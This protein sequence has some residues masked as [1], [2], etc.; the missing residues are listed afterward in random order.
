M[1]TTP[2][3]VIGPVLLITSRRWRTCGQSSNAWLRSVQVFGITWRWNGSSARPS[4]STTSSSITIWMACR[5]SWTRRRRG[6]RHGSPGSDVA[7]GS[8]SQAPPPMRLRIPRSGIPGRGSSRKTKFYAHNSSRGRLRRR[9]I[10]RLLSPAVPTGTAVPLV[11][12]PVLSGAMLLGRREAEGR[13]EE[14]KRRGS[15]GTLEVPTSPR[16]AS[17]PLPRR[18]PCLA[19]DLPELRSFPVLS[20]PAVTWPVARCPAR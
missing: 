11:L 7:E 18:G 14:E 15:A 17:K 1:P 12:Q 16:V 2:C 6:A 9:A 5:G 8:T 10:P 19:V 4:S 3:R 13:P 20:C